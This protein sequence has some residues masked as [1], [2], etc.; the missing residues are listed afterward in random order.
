MDTATT[1]DTAFAAA[2]ATYADRVAVRFGR[3]VR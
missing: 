2:S 3:A 1:L